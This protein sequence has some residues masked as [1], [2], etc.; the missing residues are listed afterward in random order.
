[1]GLS[2]QLF[3]LY[4]WLERRIAPRLRYAQYIY[5]DV[6]RE[7]VAGARCWLDL[8]CGHQVLPEWR[9]AA[10]KEMTQSVRVLVG[11]DYDFKAL[12]RNRA[13]RLRVRG[14]ISCLPFPRQCFDVVT[15]NMVAEHLEQPEVQ[16]R[17]VGR[18]LREGGVFLLHTPNVYGYTTAVARLIPERLKPWLIKLL[19]GRPREDVFRTFYRANSVSRIRLLA[20]HSGFEVVKVKR[21]ASSAAFALVPFLAVAELLWIRLLMTRRLSLFRPTLI[22]IL[23]TK[24]KRASATCQPG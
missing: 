18:V 5:E 19:E 9:T 20:E 14:D 24:P 12:R 6:L 1:M 4:W 15:A 17:E 16:F 22:A 11:V 21:V 10:E 3:R 8:G 7:H 23:R 13:I 2:R